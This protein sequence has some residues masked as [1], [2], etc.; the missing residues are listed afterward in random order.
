ML[1]TGMFCFADGIISEEDEERKTKPFE[2]KNF[3]FLFSFRFELEHGLRL[4]S[5]NHTGTMYK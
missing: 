1:Y 4:L 3:F 2:K 5:E